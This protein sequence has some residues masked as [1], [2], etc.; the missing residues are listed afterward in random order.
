MFRAAIP[1]GPIAIC[2]LLAGP[3][4]VRA[5]SY[6]G[7]GASDA[8]VKQALLGTRSLSRQRPSAAAAATRPKAKPGASVHQQ[9]ARPAAGRAAPTAK[10][11]AAVGA[12]TAAAASEAPASDSTGDEAQGPASFAIYFELGSANL[13]ADSL[14]VLDRLGAALAS[15]ELKD[16]RFVVE[17]HTDASGSEQINM[18]LSQ[19]R[20]D[21]VRNY[22]VEKHNIGPER[23]VPQG[24][25]MSEL[26]DPDHPLSGKNR[27]VRFVNADAGN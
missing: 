11:A 14:P 25:G 20:A 2:L 12:A 9:G 24:R 13:R 6:L 18:A 7:S 15:P 3:A 17:G 1:L 22:L 26:L 27:R 4:A 19:A 8:Q 16:E 21:A 10:G 23:L 5:E